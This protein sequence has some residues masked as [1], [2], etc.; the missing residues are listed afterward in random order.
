VSPD[1]IAKAA[2]FFAS[3]DSNLI[4]S[5]T[6]LFVDGVWRKSEDLGNACISAGLRIILTYQ[7]VTHEPFTW[8]E[9]RQAVFP[10]GLALPIIATVRQAR[11]HRTVD[12]AHCRKTSLT[13]T[14]VSQVQTSSGLVCCCHAGWVFEYQAQN[15][16]SDR[17]GA[18]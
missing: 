14:T 5:G 1:G 18:M 13:A 2:S 9:G 16:V 4:T 7:G 6:E 17:K 11:H 12:L 15:T 8:I 3:D 10:R